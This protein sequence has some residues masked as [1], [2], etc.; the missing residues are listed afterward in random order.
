M[1]RFLEKCF[2]AYLDLPYAYQRRRL[3]QLRALHT[4]VVAVWKTQGKVAA[5]HIGTTPDIR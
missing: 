1:L 4:E 5:L 3:D 2:I